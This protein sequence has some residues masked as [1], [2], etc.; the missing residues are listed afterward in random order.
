MQVRIGTS[1]WSYD[2]W[3]GA[4]YP[5]EVPKRRWLSFY[6]ERFDTVEINATFYRLPT[7]GTVRGWVGAVPDRFRFA[8]KMSRYLTHVRRLGDT[9]GIDRFAAAIAGLGDR[10]GP[11]LVQLP[12]RFPPDPERLAA[13]LAAMPDRWQVGVEFRDPRWFD[14]DVRTV[15]EA[16]GAALVWSDHPGSDSP[17]WQT[18]PFVYVRRH[19]T[20]GR[21]A[22]RYGPRLIELAH[23]LVDARADAWCYFNNDLDAA[24]PRDAAELVRLVE[25]IRPDAMPT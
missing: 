17:R 4:F 14:D 1:G 8:A 20:T 16:H 19:G 13:F 9:G 22:G 25:E 6:A 21:F 2:H 7:G 5:P 12:P 18:A 24:A 3:R 15:L 10:L 23:A 11:V